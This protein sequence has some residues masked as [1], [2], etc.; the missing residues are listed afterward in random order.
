MI[1]HPALL[2]EIDAFL[3]DSGMGESYFGKKATGN[4]EV[5]ARLRR[6]GRVWPDTEARL[7]SFILLRRTMGSHIKGK[8]SPA[9]TQGKDCDAL[10]SAGGTP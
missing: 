8:S 7:R 4:S 2:Q 10:K 3:A 5:V 1:M 9:D 6:G